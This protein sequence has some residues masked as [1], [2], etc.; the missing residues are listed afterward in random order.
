MHVSS[1]SA[2]TAFD[3]DLHGSAQ[4]PENF[5]LPTLPTLKITSL[6]NSGSFATV[7]EAIDTCSRER[8]AVKVLSKSNLSKTHMETL[9]R[10]VGIMKRIQAER[11]PGVV[12]L[13]RVVENEHWLFLVLEYCEIDLYDAITESK[14]PAHAVLPIFHALCRTLTHLHSLSIY[15]RDIKPENILLTSPHSANGYSHSRRVRLADFG[16]STI[17]PCSTDL[18]CGSSRYMAPECLPNARKCACS[19][20]SGAFN[21]DQDDDDCDIAR[22]DPYDCA[23]ADAWSLGVVLVNLVT[24]KNPWYEADLSDPLYAAYLSGKPVLRH[25]FGFSEKFDN[26]VRSILDPNPATRCAVR[27]VWEKVKAVRKIFDPIPPEV[28]LPVTSSSSP[29]V[30]E[31]LPKTV[32]VTPTS[33]CSSTNVS[34]AVNPRIAGLQLTHDA[35]FYRPST[36]PINTLTT[37]SS[38]PTNITTTSSLFTASPPRYIATNGAMHDSGFESEELCEVFGKEECCTIASPGREDDEDVF[39]FDAR[40]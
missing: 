11:V 23:K 14:L 4:A 25:T 33:S 28:P 29:V 16:L 36:P 37:C 27:D 35:D 26:V 21:S 2:Q 20:D 13:F 22:A 8:Y 6:I 5:T 7:Y 19:T 24:G 34:A 30:V 17:Y 32:I 38:A 10:E 1:S 3:D 12:K 39:M 40:V 18:G 31:T 9:W 15:H